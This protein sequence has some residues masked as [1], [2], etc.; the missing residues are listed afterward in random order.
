MRFT[1]IYRAEDGTARFGDD[2]I[3]FVSSEFAPPA[4]PLDVSSAVPATEM[5]FIRFPAG[6]TDPAHPAPARQWMFIL[7]GRGETTAGA[8]TRSWTAGD[9]FLLEDTDGVGH[10]TTAFEETV[11]AVVRV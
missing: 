11:M 10:G 2:D 7:S 9:V 3:S 6:W 8:D 1:R 5:L 4:P